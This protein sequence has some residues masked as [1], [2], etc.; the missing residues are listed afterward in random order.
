MRA[1]ARPLPGG[2]HGI[3]SVR[4]TS[5]RIAASGIPAASRRLEHDTPRPLRGTK[6]FSFDIVRWRWITSRSSQ[7][8]SATFWHSRPSSSCATDRNK[9]EPRGWKGW[10]CGRACRRDLS[11]ER[12]LIEV[13]GSTVY[14]DSPVSKTISYIRK[15]ISD[16]SRKPRYVETVSKVG[17]RL[18]APVSLPEDYR[19]MPSERWTKG[20]PYVGLSAFGADH[21]SVCGRSRSCGSAQ[22]MRVHIEISGRFRTDRRARAGKPALLRAGR[23]LRPSGRLDGCACPVP[24]AIFRQWKRPAVPLTA[25]LAPDARTRPFFPPQHRSTEALLTETPNMIEGF[26]AKPSGALRRDLATDSTHC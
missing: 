18:I 1:Q 10:S 4:F 16:D 24:H 5:I 9:F 12:L 2:G 15:S 22:A 26:A 25:A 20:S 13:W 17:Y 21:A 19:R 11:T 3:G 6:A 23:S 8:R 14:G 7:F